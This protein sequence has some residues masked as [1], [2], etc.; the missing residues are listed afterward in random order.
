MA[1]ISLDR[2]TQFGV[3]GGRQPG[4]LGVAFLHIHEFGFAILIR[5]GDLQ[6]GCLA[7][8]SGLLEE[9]WRGFDQQTLPAAQQFEEQAVRT[10]DAVITADF[11]KGAVAFALEDLFVQK[12]VLPGL[13]EEHIPAAVQFFAFPDLLVYLTARACMGDFA[14]KLTQQA[15][16][17]DHCLFAASDDFAGAHILAL[18][19]VFLLV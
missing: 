1:G 16:P 12:R 19:F 3:V 15:M 2:F 6:A 9:R 5:Q 18:R 11:D 10:G 13:T 7:E 8:G 4:H 14:G 17:F